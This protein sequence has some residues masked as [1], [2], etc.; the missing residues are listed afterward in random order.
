M[1]EVETNSMKNDIKRFTQEQSK[2]ILFKILI[3]EN[4]QSK[5]KG[6][7]EKIKFNTQ[8]PHLISS[9]AEVIINQITNPIDL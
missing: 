4:Y 8:L 3:L 1:L 5:I 6:N 2:H 7:K 9:V